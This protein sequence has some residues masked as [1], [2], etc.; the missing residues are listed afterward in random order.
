MGLLFVP[1]Q[2]RGS[3]AALPYARP[4]GGTGLSEEVLR[5]GDTACGTCGGTAAR[6]VHRRARANRARG[7]VPHTRDRCEGRSTISSRAASWSPGNRVRAGE[8]VPECRPG[9]P[10][11]GQTG[12]KR[13]YRSVGFTLCAAIA[14][15][16][17]LLPHCPPARPTITFDPAPHAPPR[18]RKSTRLNSS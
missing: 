2:A 10:S 12:K 6:C 14:G 16:R 18:D 3:V 1:G 13:G 17:R 9:T 4:L 8:L 7:L 5:R 15:P 11:A